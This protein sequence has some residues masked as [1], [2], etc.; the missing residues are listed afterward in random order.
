M[1]KSAIEHTVRGTAADFKTQMA[2]IGYTFG[3]ATVAFR[4]G[5]IAKTRADVQYIGD[6][7]GD[8]P[9]QRVQFWGVRAARDAAAFENLYNAG[10]AVTVPLTAN[11]AALT[12]RHD[13]A[14]VD[15]AADNVLANDMAGAADDTPGPDSLP[16]GWLEGGFGPAVTVVG[17]NVEAGDANIDL[18]WQGAVNDSQRTLL[19]HATTADAA[20]RGDIWHLTFG[21]KIVAGDF[22]AINKVGLRIHERDSG[23]S[24]LG[25]TADDDAISLAAPPARQAFTLSRVFSKDGAAHA[26]SQIW[27]DWD[28]PGTCD[29]A[30][31]IYL[32]QFARQQV[33]NSLYQ[34]RPSFPN[35]KTVTRM[36]GLPPLTSGVVLRG[37]NLAGADF[38]GS[39]IPGVH[40]GDY[41]YP[42]SAYAGADYQAAED[43]VAKGY[44]CFRVPFK[45]PRL[46]PALQGAFDTNEQARLVTTVTQLTDLGAYAVLD[47][48]DGGGYGGSKIN[49]P[50]VSG[51]VSSPTSNAVVLSAGSRIDDWYNG[52]TINVDGNDYTVS[53][54]A[55]QTRTCTISGTFSPALSGGEAFTITTAAQVAT[56]DFEDFWNRLA[57]LFKGNLQVVFGIMNEPSNMT[58]A[59]WYP[60]LQAAINEIRNVAGA[61]NLILAPGISWTGAHSWVTSGNAVEMLAIT[62]P[63][64]GGS[65]M[66]IEAHQYFDSDSSG[67]S[68]TCVAPDV[69]IA[70][71]QV[72]TDWLIAN[73]KKGFIGEFGGSGNLNCRACMAAFLAHVEANDA[74]VGWTPWAMGPWWADAYVD[75]LD[76]RRSRM[77]NTVDVFVG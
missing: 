58:A 26:H 2:G 51:T 29:I 60:A 74:Y 76:D 19:F 11:D 63:L 48:H 15:F 50:N 71:I 67:I 52:L 33:V 47:P 46:Q 68:S 35:F 62:D 40:G 45:W 38:A 4:D 66:A 70:R 5:D 23:G 12:A 59:E 31:R 55:G 6:L 32:P 75:N 44:N 16:T 27:I 20:V 61:T 7:A 17:V 34:K 22:T 18:R 43:A 54:Y 72:F 13:A 65:N 64:A 9:H 21:A 30:L 77:L 10:V 36:S 8:G 14:A 69:V 73:G 1:A 56:A 39:K 41:I 37:F 57:T 25:W 42:V 28:P 53:D 3:D 49:Q 24:S